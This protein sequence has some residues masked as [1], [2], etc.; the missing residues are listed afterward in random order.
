LP[1][2]NQWSRDPEASLETWFTAAP[3][4]R[5]ANFDLVMLDYRSFGKSTGRIE[6]QAQLEA[7]VRA[8]WDALA[9]AYLGE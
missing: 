8:V 5:R 6:G 9:P 2:R 3:A 4:F 1:C 7:D